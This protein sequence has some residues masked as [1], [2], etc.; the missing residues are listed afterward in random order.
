MNSVK[1]VK[2]KSEKLLYARTRETKKNRKLKG[3]LESNRAKWY[4]LLLSEG[5]SWRTR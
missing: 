1:V 2:A 3:E 5:R 4:M